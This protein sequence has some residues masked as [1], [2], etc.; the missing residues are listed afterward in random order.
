M[1]AASLS[2][3]FFSGV[4]LYWIQPHRRTW[5]GWLAAMPPLAVTVWQLAAA[6][7]FLSGSSGT[8]SD[9]TVAVQNDAILFEQYRWIESLGLELSFR[10]DGLSLLFGLIIAGVGAAVALYTHYYLENDERQGYFYLS[11]FAF[12]A[13]MLGLVWADNL[14]T[15][16]VF[17]EGTSVTSYLL[18]GYSHQSAVARGGARNA[19]IVTAG[20]GLA[21]IAGMVL[22]GQQSGTYTIS[23]IVASPGLTDLDYYPAI[24]ILILLGAFTKS[25]QFP[26]HFWLPG[27]MAAPTPAS[28]YLHSA[29]M[30]KAGIYLLARLHPALSGHPLWL[31]A[32]LIFGGATMLIGAIAAVRHWDMKALLAYAT[33]SQ[34]GIL[35]TLLAFRSEAALLAVVVGVLAHALYKGPLFLVAGIVDHATGTRDLRKLAGLRHSLPVTSGTA[36]L[37]TVSMAGIPP[38]FGFVSKEALLE[39]FFEFGEHGELAGWIA[40]GAA[41]LAGA[42]FV[43]YSLTLLWE[44]FLRPGATGEAES[45]A[46]GDSSQIAQTH[47]HH[48]PPAP[49]LAAPILL[50]AIGTVAPFALKPL[51]PFLTSA[52]ASIYGAPVHKHAAL[53]HGF[54][55]VLLTSLLA[56]A[57]GFWLFQNRSYIR[58][59][60]A[61]LPENLR[62]VVVF[63]NFLDG[64]YALGQFTARFSQGYT[65]ATQAAIVLLAAFVPVAVALLQVAPGELLPPSGALPGAPETVLILLMV[66]SAYVTV[67]IRTRLGAIVSLGVVGVSVTLFYVFFSAPDLAL[68]QLLIEVLTV[69]LLVL[70]FTK[71][72]PDIRPPMQKLKQTR[73]VLVALA[74]GAFGF[75]LVLF[76]TSEAMQAA[77]SISDY[78]LHNAVP[79]G[80]G[81][82][83]VNVILVDFRAFDTMGEITVLALAALGGYALLNAPRVNLPSWTSQRPESEASVSRQSP[84]AAEAEQSSSESPVEA[85]EK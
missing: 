83:V 10:L 53:W 82:N 41:A 68:T 25:A 79:E 35:T 16:F 70:V 57:A 66:V 71:L 77:R 8:S 20:G 23:E 49:F 11:L 18:I 9:A 22:L 76:N 4:I 47:V 48:A 74:A 28:A 21:L 6:V 59:G 19:F 29:T 42:F 14:L 37:A 64:V 15:L 34:L 32:L 43:T 55:P 72:P 2:L 58:R 63:Q 75:F 62:G 60:L 51:D 31:W 54:T 78:F 26:F 1:L 33:V 27:A 17:W 40:F 38:L 44:A 69:V 24:L 46:K 45:S 39:S 65:L 5:A 81:T 30:V 13:S 36:M 52:A 84:T 80:H 73:N 7:P 50:V 61:L 56:I 12:M 3:I 67:R 85:G